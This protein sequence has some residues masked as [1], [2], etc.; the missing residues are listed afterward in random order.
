M[1]KC[2]VCG[3]EYEK[4]NVLKNL[5]QEER[6]YCDACLIAGVEVYEDLVGFGWPYDL[7]SDSYKRKI[8][9]PTLQYNNKTVEQFNEEVRRKRD[10]KIE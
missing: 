8:I 10:E 5:T 6:N 9:F 7:F 1:I 4:I 2:D 3:N